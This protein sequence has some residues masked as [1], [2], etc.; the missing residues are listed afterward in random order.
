LTRLKK[1][2]LLNDFYSDTIEDS[3]VAIVRLNIADLK[4]VSDICEE[5]QLDFDDAYQ[6][7]ASE[8]YDMILVSFDSD[9]KQMERKSKTP[10]MIMN[11]GKI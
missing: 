7:V 2:G 8:N 10:A 5:S 1:H 4:Q 9:F 11:E 6:Y 3:G